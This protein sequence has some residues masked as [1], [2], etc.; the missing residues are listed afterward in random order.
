MPSPTICY[1]LG[2]VFCGSATL[3]QLR[4]KLPFNM[5]S[6]PKGSPWRPALLAFIEDAGGIE[7][8]GGVDYR[9]QVMKRYD[10][11]PRFRRMVLILTWAWGLGL[12][13]IAIVATVLIMVLT[14]NVGFGVGWGLPYAWAAV[15]SILTVVFVKKE[16]RK[17][18][19]EW[20]AKE[21]A[22]PVV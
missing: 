19:A 8:Q 14:E 18:K 21:A 6:T 20:R 22:R 3:T 10:A 11:S 12:I 13:G 16:L 1:W 7:G 17:E 2:L 15:W 9:R 5:S 4:W